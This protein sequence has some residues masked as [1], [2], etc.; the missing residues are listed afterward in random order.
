M[1]AIVLG[2]TGAV[3]RAL[4]IELVNNSKYEEVRAITRRDY[5]F[6]ITSPRFNTKVIDFSSLDK[7][8][9]ELKGFDAVYC[10][11][12]TTRAA[13]GGAENFV[14]IDQDLTIAT[15]N[16][17]LTP[18]LTQQ[19]LYVSSFGA[20]EAS[21]FLYPK[22]KGQTE[23]RLKELG[24][25]KTT[26]FRPGFLEVPGGREKPK[27]GESIFGPFMSS[28]RMIGVKRMSA[29]VQEVAMAMRIVAEDSTK[30]SGNEPVT[31]AEILALSG[32]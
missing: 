8:A 22:S 5:D 23:R 10:S 32:N 2:S 13:A 6:G 30:H 17:A 7:H 26:I 1:K 27:F 28:F 25:A 29:S 18:G 21:S 3:G 16:A 12:G 9:D 19:L 31:N 4:V 20:S 24:F 11:M 14:K 15:V